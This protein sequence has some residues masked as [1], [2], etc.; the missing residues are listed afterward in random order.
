M[1]ILPCP[2]CNQAGQLMQI[3]YT[4]DYR[5]K[6]VFYVFCESCRARTH[7]YPRAQQAI[8]HWNRRIKNVKL[9]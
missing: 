6:I 8:S 1:E 2:F 7:R 4:V 9:D 5:E 3:D